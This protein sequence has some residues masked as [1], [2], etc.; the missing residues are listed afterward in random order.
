MR[1]PKRP[2]VCDPQNGGALFCGFLLQPI[3]GASWRRKKKTG[4]W[5]IDSCEGSHKLAVVL[6]GAGK[7]VATYSHPEDKTE[8]HVSDGNFSL[9]EKKYVYILAENVLL[10]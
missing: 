10:I 9:A 2:S 4:E 3:Q 1:Q 7:M 8:H 5:L 6:Q